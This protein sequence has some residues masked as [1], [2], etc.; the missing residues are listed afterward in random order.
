MKMAA[1]KTTAKK[2]TPKTT[3]PRK[4]ARKTVSNFDKLQ[5]AGVIPAE[6]I[7]DF[8]DSH[9]QAIRKMTPAELNAVIKLKSK[10]GDDFIKSHAPH[11][12]FF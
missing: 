4:T 6:R 12:F 7:G 2:A 10:L 5:K 3:T 1:K 11:A 9:K 8:T